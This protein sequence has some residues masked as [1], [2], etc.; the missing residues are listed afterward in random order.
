MGLLMICTFAGLLF[1]Q[2]RPDE[3]T[4]TIAVCVIN[5][6]NAKPL[7]NVSVAL[8]SEAGP[9][10]KNSAGKFIVGVTNKV[11]EVTLL[12][13]SPLPEKIRIS[14]AGG[15]TCQLGQCS[16][17][18]TFR[19]A[20]VLKTG[21]VAENKCTAPKREYGASPKPGELVIFVKPYT[22]WQCAMQEI[23]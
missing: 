15:E 22:R 1:A 16:S 5:S 18:E 8:H 10:L 14:C 11:G 2:P 19:T 12:L 4:H 9:F 21:M 20:E 17:S 3:V 7:K 23:P 6:T 13:P